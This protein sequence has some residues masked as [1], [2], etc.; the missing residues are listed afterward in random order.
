MQTQI[1]DQAGRVE[2]PRKTAAPAGI[3][4]RHGRAC[5]IHSGGS[6]TCDPTYRAWVYSKVDKKKIRKSFPTLAAAKGWRT[7]AM[8]AV[9]D[10]KMQAPTTRTLRDEVESWLAGATAG[11]I[12]K[13]K[14]EERYK[15]SVLRLYESSLRLRVLPE[16][17]DRRLSDLDRRDLLNLKESLY[18]AGCSDSQIRN[19]LVALMAVIRRAWSREDIPTLPTLDLGLPTPA[20]RTRAATPAQAA[21]LLSVL[22]EAER[23]LWATAFYAG[24]RRGELRGLRVSDLNLEAG[25][26]SVERGWDEKHGPIAPKSKA[27]TRQALLCAT[28]R[29]YLEPLAVG[30]PDALLFGSA[31]TAFEPRNVERKARR[32]VQAEN[33][34]RE[35]AELPPVQWFGL[36]EARHSFSTAMDHAGISASRG[37]R[38]MGHSRGG[39]A[40][41]YRKLLPDQIAEDARRLD[42][43]LSGSVAGKVVEI[44]RAESAA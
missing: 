27:G 38:Y 10:R 6:C 36:H 31:A 29:P 8:K 39:A 37:D 19:A 28:L 40:E 18:G 15:P 34:R 30:E 42:A 17:G 22:P 35:R 25:T 13:P 5:N 43:Y 24:L 16:L 23:A 41:G 7:D 12:R 1:T 44:S 9:K 20:G 21:E 11:T 32:A 3:T 33:D 2:R 26:I 4:V 14:T